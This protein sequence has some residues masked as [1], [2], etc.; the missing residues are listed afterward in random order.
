MMVVKCGR[1]L[2]CLR[3]FDIWLNVLSDFH[4]SR[5]VMVTRVVVLPIP[6]HNFWNKVA[7][8]VQ[9]ILKSNS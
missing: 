3:T 2:K 8:G 9:Q 4:A 5:D 7:C 6:K 1:Y